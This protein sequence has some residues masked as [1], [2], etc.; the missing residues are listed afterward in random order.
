MAN[1]NRISKSRDITLPAKICLVKAMVFPVVLYGCEG[2]TIKK[3]EPQRIDAFES[4]FGRTFE[5]PL[6]GKEIQSVHPKTNKSWI[7]IEKTNAEAETLILW[8]PDA[9]TSEKT[10]ML[11]KTEGGK[12]RDNTHKMVGWHHRL[13]GREFE[14]SL[15]V[16][17]V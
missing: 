15:G 2:L 14:Y 3:A 10:L 8:T 4:W 6:D 5:S 13:D 16:V 9:K 12:R 11:G 1:L 7:F 17:D